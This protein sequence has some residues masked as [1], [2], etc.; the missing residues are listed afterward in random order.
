[1]FKRSAVPE[2]GVWTQVKV[3]CRPDRMLWYCGVFPS[4]IHLVVVVHNGNR[5]FSTCNSHYFTRYKSAVLYGF[6]T[7]FTET[8]GRLFPEVGGYQ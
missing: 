8:T 6:V 5:P 2:K 7:L 4:S 3:W 1:M